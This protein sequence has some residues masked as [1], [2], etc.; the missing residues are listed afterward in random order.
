MI[1]IDQ[2][3]ELVQIDVSSALQDQLPEGEGF[4]LDEDF[5]GW[6]DDPLRDTDQTRMVVPWTW[7]GINA[8]LLGLDATGKPVVVRGVTIVTE[9]HGQFLCHRYVDWLPALSQAGIVLFTRPLRPITERYD[10]GELLEVPDYAAAAKEI[11]EV[12]E[13]FGL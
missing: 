3:I 13:R 9:A 6:R 2:A 8:G 1:E 10:E 7:S 5:D 11:A 12:R 4:A